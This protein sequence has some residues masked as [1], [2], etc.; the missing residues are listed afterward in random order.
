MHRTV[1]WISFVLE[2]RWLLALK[3]GGTYVVI[4]KRGFPP[5]ILISYVVAL[6][7]RSIKYY[8]IVE[9]DQTPTEFEAAQASMSRRLVYWSGQYT[10][11]GN[12]EILIKSVAQ[13]IRTY[14]MSVFRLPV[15]VLWWFNSH[16]ATI[17]NGCRE[18]E[19]EDVPVKLGLDDI[20][21]TKSRLGV[22]RYAVF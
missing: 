17:L 22:P 21:K 12:K 7:W 5:N 10:Y 20:T 9:I 8:K 3:Q 4:T 14:V 2:A 18:G 1:E 16:D 15:S 6:Q 11:S 19:E 13:A